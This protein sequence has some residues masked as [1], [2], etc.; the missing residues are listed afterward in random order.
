MCSTKDLDKFSLLHGAACNLGE[1]YVRESEIFDRYVRGYEQNDLSSFLVESQY[2]NSKLSQISELL[3]QLISRGSRIHSRTGAIARSTPLLLLITGYF[4]STGTQP[5]D[6]SVKSKK[7]NGMYPPQYNVVLPLIVWLE[8]LSG[9][10]INL[11]EYGRKECL[12]HIMKKVKK[13]FVFVKFLRRQQWSSETG[14]IRLISFTY[15]PKP[16]DWR[17]WFTEE[18]DESF[19]DF[20]DM[21]EHP[22]R[23]MPGSWND[24][25]ERD[26]E[27]E[28]WSDD[29]CSDE[30]PIAE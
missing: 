5:L 21:I 29:D 26:T 7:H 23:A 14:H 24:R 17:F 20:W 10:G 19:M 22:E 30:E 3:N 8:L 1:L 13:R 6:S 28:D 16:R 4:H 12:I 27:L 25:L 15:G 9:A 2:K 18:M 11:C